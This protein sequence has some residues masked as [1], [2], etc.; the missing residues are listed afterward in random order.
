MH[1]P[2]PMRRKLQVRPW[3]LVIGAF[4]SLVTARVLFDDVWHGAEI[5]TSHLLSLA[6]IVVA[7]SAGHYA[8]PQLKARAVVSGAMLG[9]LFLGAT[10]YVV[11][12]SGARNAEQAAAKASLASDLNDRR[13]RELYQLS[14]AEKMLA[15]A[16]SDLARE[17]RSGRGKR[18]QGIETTITVYEAAIRGHK[19][20]LAEI[21][22]ERHANGVYAHMAKTLAAVTG[23]NETDI[24]ARLILVMPFLAVLLSELGTITFLHMALTHRDVPA[25]T[26]PH[27]TAETAQTSF[28]DG[29][30]DPRWFQ[31]DPTPP[32]GPRKSPPKLP[33][34]VIAL[35]TKHPVIRALEAN[36]G[37]ARSNLELAELLGVSPGEASK[38][39]QEVADQLRTE[40]VGKE[41]RISIKRVA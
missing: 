29:D 28:P 3:P 4:L 32:R 38:S 39:W 9:I 40:R 1:P 31:P 8:I 36:G 17:C 18:C 16:Q 19:A 2:I 35:T 41:L 7:L 12:S 21:G 11:M 23:G 33:A 27:S 13:D 26:K 10:A 24:M 6:A 15:G 37:A 25:P 5:T 20:T 34:N 30:L 14:E 22:P